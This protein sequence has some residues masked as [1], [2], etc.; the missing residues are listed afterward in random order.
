MTEIL[1]LLEEDLNELKSHK[2][3]LLLVTIWLKDISDIKKMDEIWDKWIA[4]FGTPARVVVEANLN[5]P[6]C[7]IEISAIASRKL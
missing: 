4:G 7:F 6:D 5:S 3:R 2:S 1:I